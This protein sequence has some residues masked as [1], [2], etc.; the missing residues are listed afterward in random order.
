MKRHEAIR[1][2]HRGV[3]NAGYTWPSVFSSAHNSKRKV[4]CSR[5]DEHRS[6]HGVMSAALPQRDVIIVGGGYGALSAA[7][8]LHRVSPVTLGF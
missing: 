7:V 8:A 3:T 4:V 2:N 1:S 5:L 6:S